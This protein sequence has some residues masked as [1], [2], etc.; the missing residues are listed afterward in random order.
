MY[1]SEHLLLMELRPQVERMQ[2][3]RRWTDSDVKKMLFA[4]ARDLGCKWR[5]DKLNRVIDKAFGKKECLTVKM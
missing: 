4:F 5:R 2:E 1:M 3:E